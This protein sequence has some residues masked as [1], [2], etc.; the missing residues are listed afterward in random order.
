MF[1][2]SSL[3]YCHIIITFPYN[4]AHKS[5]LKILHATKVDLHMSF[6]GCRVASLEQELRGSDAARR[7][8]AK[9][10]QQVDSGTK[11]PFMGSAVLCPQWQEGCWRQSWKGVDLLS[12]TS[13]P[14]T[15]IPRG[16]CAWVD[17]SMGKTP[18]P[19]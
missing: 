17:T 4:Y 12:P 19:H 5:H 1:C 18:F 15:L 7:P 14:R 16:I 2:F 13:F 10:T 8:G 9:Q 11:A 3:F 6:R